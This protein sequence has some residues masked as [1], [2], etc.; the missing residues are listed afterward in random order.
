MCNCW[1]NKSAKKY[2]N[3][4]KPKQSD[5]IDNEALKSSIEGKKKIINK[6]KIVK[7]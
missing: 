7:K 6:D 2:V 1:K 5:K 3:G 4:L